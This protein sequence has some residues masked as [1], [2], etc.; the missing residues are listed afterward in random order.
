MKITCLGILTDLL[1]RSLFRC[2]MSIS[3]KKAIE[4]ADTVLAYLSGLENVAHTP[5]LTHWP[6]KPFRT[7]AVTPRSLPVVACLPKV[8][9]ATDKQT[10]AVIK[11]LVAAAKHLFWG[12]TYTQADFG[13]DF[14]QNYGWTELIGLRGP[15]ANSVIACGF[16]LLGP[17]TLYPLHSHAAE[18]IYVPLS[19]PTFWTQSQDDWVAR[20]RGE[21]IYH[22]SGLA[23]G[24][25][26]ES[27]PL[28]ALYL[29]R[30][31]DLAQKSHIE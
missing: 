27:T 20:P 28:L 29:W 5:F 16:L 6:S 1:I 13:R 12:Q 17:D 15:I 18:E 7:R 14:L 2:N 26:T 3:M 9:A 21:P 22:R 19:T 24:M 4:L 10:A 30:G 31:G 11:T 23:H 25:R 8:A